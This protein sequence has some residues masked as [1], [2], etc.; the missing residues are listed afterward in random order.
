MIFAGGIPLKRNGRVV[1]AT[2]VSGGSG[3]ERR[4]YPIRQGKAFGRLGLEPFPLVSMAEEGGFVFPLVGLSLKIGCQQV[5]VLFFST[6]RWHI[7][8]VLTERLG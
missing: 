6:L 1:G 4:T 3:C 8:A 2:V 5:M 7:D